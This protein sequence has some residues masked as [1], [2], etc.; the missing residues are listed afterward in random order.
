M[1]VIFVAACLCTY[2]VV[3]RMPTFPV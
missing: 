1:D 3:Y 2:N